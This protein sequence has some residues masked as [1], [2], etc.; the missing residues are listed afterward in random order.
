MGG[1]GPQLVNWGGYD[2][3]HRIRFAPGATL[4][5]GGSG[6]GKSTLMDSYI[7]LLMP[8]TT[9]F[10]GAS[11]GGVV[12]LPR[13]K[14]QRNILSYARGKLDESRTDGETR[15]R[16]LRGDGRDT[17]TAIAM[18][19]ADRSGEVFTALR[20][21][22]VPSSARAL[23]DVVVVRAVRD[24]AYDLRE[25]DGPAGSRFARDALN[26]TGL[27]CFGTDRDFTA[28]LH[29]SLGIGAAAG[30]ATRR[31]GCS[32]GSRPASR[33]RPSTR[34]TRRWSWRSRPPWPRRTRWCSSSTSCPAPGS[35]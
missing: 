24:E 20:A 21:W 25:L 19:W 32:A 34:C 15:V 11:N 35:G 4:F 30:T 2:G 18:T 16:V 12:G 17:W 31:S 6:S 3:Y 22:Y 33:S 9:P 14:D 8:H 5:S 28:R 23:D 27:T 10:N 29:T 26:A 7:A 13:G 1:A